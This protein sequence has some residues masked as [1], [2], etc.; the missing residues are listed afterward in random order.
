MS[1]YENFCGRRL[2][3]GETCLW[4]GLRVFLWMGV[5][6]GVALRG[7]EGLGVHLERTA[8]ELVVSGPMGEVCRY[9][10]ESGALR[11]PDGVEAIYSGSGFFSSLRT[12]CGQELADVFAVGQRHHRGLFSAWVRVGVEGREVDVWNVH[13][14]TG[15]TEADGEALM[16]GD[17]FV[18]RRRHVRSEGTVLLEET[19]RVSVEAGPRFNRVDLEVDQ[20]VVVEG[21]VQ[22]ERHTYGGVAFRASR[23]WNPED[24]AHYLGEALVWASDGVRDRV[25]ANHHAA[26]W[27][28]MEGPLPGG[29]GGL[30]IL[31]HRD[32]HRYPQRVRVHPKYPYWVFCPVVEAP[33]PLEQGAHIHARYR[34]LTF[35]ERPEI[36]EIEAEWE[37]FVNG[38]N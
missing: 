18:A 1:K 34:I 2:G 20:V 30:V 21:G 32:T 6:T 9:V 31:Q 4:R 14:G 13:K 7:S 17:G 8:G 38:A 24:A 26:R 23:H 28:L 35:D 3:G 37:R 10:E 12:P 5:M 36:G 27:V 19:W 15:R 29:R 11:L 22:L 25:A 33:W 16:G